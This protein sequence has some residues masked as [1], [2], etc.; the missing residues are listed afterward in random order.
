MPKPDSTHRFSDRVENYV[1]YRPSYPAEAIAYLQN[2]AIAPTSTVADIG[3]GTGIMTQL[4]LPHCQAIFAVEP[5]AAMR[6]K[7]E[8]DLGHMAGFQSRSGTAEATG[9]EANSVDAIVCAQAYHWFDSEATLQEFRRIVRGPRMLFLVWNDRTT[10]TP[11]LVHYEALLKEFG[12]DYTEVNHQ[13]IT[14]AQLRPIFAAQYEKKEF[15]NEQRLDLY[16]VKGRLNS[17]SYVPKPGDPR[18][19]MLMRGVEE[20]FAQHSENGEVKILYSTTIYS[21]KI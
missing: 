1:N 15:D 20:A 16:G 5:N 17:T 4:L 19:E 18:Y 8:A 11:F 14:D 2:R 12:T 9:L 7:A 21:G 3:S 6:S 13:R 10:K